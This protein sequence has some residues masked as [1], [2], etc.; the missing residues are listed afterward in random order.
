MGTTLVLWHHLICN[1]KQNSPQN[2]KK[3]YR[4][5]LGQTYCDCGDQMWS[6][7]NLNGF[8]SSIHSPW[9]CS[10]I[11]SVTGLFLTEFVHPILNCC[12][13]NFSARHVNNTVRTPCMELFCYSLRARH[14]NLS[15]KNV[16]AVTPSRRDYQL[17]QRLYPTD[18]K[19]K[20]K[21]YDIKLS[22]H[23]FVT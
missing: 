5:T 20:Q 10:G 22:T 11:I 23:D 16:Y 7:I 21:G 1:Y 4:K 8:G 13:T 17:N 12:V 3:T 9:Y 15:K 14:V 6:C 2:E 18:L 19:I